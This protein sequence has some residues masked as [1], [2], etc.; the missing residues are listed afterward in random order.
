VAA[1]QKFEI[2][3]HHPA[4]S[5]PLALIQLI[6]EETMPNLVLVLALK[7]AIRRTLSEPNLTA[8]NL[9][10]GPQTSGA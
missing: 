6:S 7:P 5:N 2:T 1:K 3:T 8:G 9:R 4:M 10:R